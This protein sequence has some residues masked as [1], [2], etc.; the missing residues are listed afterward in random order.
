MQRSIGSGP[1][2]SPKQ[3]SQRQSTNSTG[4]EQLDLLPQR[5]APRP[6]DDDHV[7]RLPSLRRAINYSLSHAEMD[8]K[9]AYGPLDMDK[10]VWSRISNGSMSFPADDLLKLAQ[11]TQNIAP[12]VW[13]VHQLG[14]ELKP[15]QSELEQQLETKNAR[16]EELE[17][18]LDII[19]NFVRQ[20]RSAG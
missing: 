4:V 15:L 9:E 19:T 14:Y 5:K 6:I 20:T 16:I 1:F 2:F 8:P 18:R 17:K 11:V 10:A 13:L 12:I 3:V 7:K